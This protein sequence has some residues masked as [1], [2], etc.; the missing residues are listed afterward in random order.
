MPLQ[1]TNTLTRRKDGFVP[2][3]PARV[4]LY[5]CG[6]TVYDLAH[7]GNARPVVVFDTLSRCSLGADEATRHSAS[8]HHVHADLCDRGTA[9]ARDLGALIFQI[10]AL[11]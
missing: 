5:V 4:R 2:L 10:S 1:L 9:A 3:D 6:P 8:C 11:E 7:I